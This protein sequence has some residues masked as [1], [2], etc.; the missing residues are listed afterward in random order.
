MFFVSWNGGEKGFYIVMVE[1]MNEMTFNKGW[2]RIK[3]N[4][5]PRPYF[6]I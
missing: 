1:N 3:E 5:E 2:K 6:V 4:H